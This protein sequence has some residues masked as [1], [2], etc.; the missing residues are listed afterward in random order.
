MT[1]V[2]RRGMVLLVDD[3]QVTKYTGEGFEVLNPDEQK[4]EAGAKDGKNSK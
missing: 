2:K 4:K 3:S 1:Y